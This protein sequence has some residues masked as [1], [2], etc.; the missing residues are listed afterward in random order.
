MQI[1]L[2]S[3][4]LI[5]CILLS[6]SPVLADGFR[7]SAKLATPVSAAS[8]SV[9]AG[10]NWTCEADAC[11]GVADKR[12]GLDSI[13]KECRKVAGTLGPL[14]SYT[15]R[16]RTFSPGN[17]NVCNRLGAESRATPAAAAQ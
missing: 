11:V 12:G 2:F 5:S 13:M 16:G 14:A 3:A 4:G 8:S 15:S 1:K 17:L 6:A 10:V 7:A 9:I